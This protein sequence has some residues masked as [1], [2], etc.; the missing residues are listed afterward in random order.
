MDATLQEHMASH[1]VVAQ[2]CKKHFCNVDEL[3]VHPLILLAVQA[4][5]KVDE[6]GSRYLLG[7]HVGNLY[8]LVLQ[9]DGEH[10][11]GLK[12]EPLG[13]TS[14]PS[15]LTYLDNGV[16]YVGSSFG[17]SQLVRHG[18]FALHDSVLQRCPGNVVVS[19]RPLIHFQRLCG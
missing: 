6:D 18:L 16:V 10:V 4:Y 17:D 2:D 9:H 15:T 13:R 1:S 14:A 12:V 5:G 11:A 3:S 8:L 7:D 19:A